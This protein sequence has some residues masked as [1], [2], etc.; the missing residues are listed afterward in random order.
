MLFIRSSPDIDPLL[1]DFLEGLILNS[2][3][4]LLNRDIGTGF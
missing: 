1:A 2:G 3:P 4:R